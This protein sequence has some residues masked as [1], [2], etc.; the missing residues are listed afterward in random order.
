MPLRE[1]HFLLYLGVSF[2]QCAGQLLRTGEKRVSFACG[3]PLRIQSG[4]FHRG[5]FSDTQKQR[6]ERWQW[7]GSY[8]GLQW[9][10]ADQGRALQLGTSLVAS[11]SPLSAAENQERYWVRIF[12]GSLEDGHRVKHPGRAQC[13]SA[14]LT[15]TPFT[16]YVLHSQLG[17]SL[18]S[19]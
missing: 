9:R 15:S 12:P 10:G 8:G 17:S 7:K 16:S 18:T 14:S 11:T 19:C 13:L 4:R 6:A 1:R 2:P 3:S 5:T